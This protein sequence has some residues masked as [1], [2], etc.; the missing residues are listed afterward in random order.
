MKVWILT[1]ECNDYNQYGEYFEYVWG[2]RPTRKDISHKTG[3]NIDS[4]LVTHILE[5]GGRK[6]YEHSWYILTEHEIEVK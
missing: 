1:S 6:N 2:Y 5:G 3:Y 4:E